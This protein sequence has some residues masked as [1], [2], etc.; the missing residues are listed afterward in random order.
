MQGG[1]KLSLEQIRA[2]LKASQEVRFAGHRRAEVYAW[3]G[4]TLREQGYAKQPRE[5]KGL[6]RTYLLKMT[7]L[8]RAQV[9]RLIGQHTSSGEVKEAVYRRRLFSTRYTRADA[10]LLATVDEARDTLSGPATRKI[11]EREF[12]ESSG[13]RAKSQHCR[14]A[15]QRTSGRR[16]L[17]ERRPNQSAGKKSQQQT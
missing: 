13:S 17:H 14:S 16:R 15:I 11:L 10:A 3:V 8:S 7:G 1:E 12:T 4:K 5:A 6:L 9:T 2:L